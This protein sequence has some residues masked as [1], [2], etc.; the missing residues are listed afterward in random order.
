V[1]AFVVGSVLGFS[2]W[3]VLV[4]GS[5]FGFSVWHVHQHREGDGVVI[6]RPKFWFK[7]VHTCNFIKIRL[8]SLPDQVLH[9]P[10]Q[11]LISLGICNDIRLYPYVSATIYDCIFYGGPKNTDG[12]KCFPI[13]KIGRIDGGR[14]FRTGKNVF[15][16]GGDTFYDREYKI[17][18]KIPESKRSEIGIIAEFRGIPNGFPNLPFHHIFPLAC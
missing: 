9:L 17:P 15:R 5:V 3:H 1:V 16:I 11:E 6:V 13:H 14:G 12:K 8:S 7:R 18:M 10:P 2:V 4:V